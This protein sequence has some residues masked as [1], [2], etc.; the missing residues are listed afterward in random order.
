MSPF[1]DLAASV[2]L[3]PLLEATAPHSFSPSW[4]RQT[5]FSTYHEVHAF[6]LGV[7]AGLLV[8]GLRSRGY[9]HTGTVL[10]LALFAFT[11]GFPDIYDVCRKP[12]AAC[13]S[14]PVQLQPWY[15]LTGLIVVSVVGPRLVAGLRR[16]WRRWR[17]SAS[18]RAGSVHERAAEPRRGEPAT[19]GGRRTPA[20]AAD[21]RDDER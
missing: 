3:G 15:F 17:H 10:T 4:Y 16:A 18:R 9:R 6:Q 14:L 13:G 11:M 19:D 20:L 1:L 21:A 8:V 7:Y 2:G 12:G 5:M